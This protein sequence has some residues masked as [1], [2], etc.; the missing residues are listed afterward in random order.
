MNQHK[1]GLGGGCHWCTEAVFNSLIGVSLVQQGFIKDSPHSTYSEAVIV[2]YNPSLI[3]LRDLISIHLF[4]HQS[5]SNHSM[6]TK[7]RSA[8]YSFSDIDK[9]EAQQQLV[10]L[11]IEFT[12]PLITQVLPF[13]EFKASDV[14]F[15]NYFYTRP[16]K[17]FCTNYII[18]K[19]QVLLTKYRKLTKEDQV[20][21][22]IAP[23]TV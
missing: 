18:P 1:I 11:Q 9:I 6:R 4:T 16:D 17:P 14:S 21:A 23:K 15:Q 2:H 13:E 3:S 7:Y 20:K 8:I 22:S 12:E 19:L 5:T 10:Q